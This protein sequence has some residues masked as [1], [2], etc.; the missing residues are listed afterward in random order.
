[1]TQ[2]NGLTAVEALRVLRDAQAM[3]LIAITQTMP[4]EQRAAVA[5]KL[6]GL[7]A[8]AEKAGQVPLESALIDLHRAVVGG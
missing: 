4:P 5:A 6:A 1:M 3:M 7:A 2:P 8:Q